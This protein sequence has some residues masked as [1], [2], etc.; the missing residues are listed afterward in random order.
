ME[1]YWKICEVSYTRWNIVIFSA[2]YDD[3]ELTI[4]TYKDT[5]RNASFTV[6]YLTAG[7]NSDDDYD[8][9][10]LLRSTDLQHVKNW[11]KTQKLPSLRDYVFSKIIDMPDITNNINELMTEFTCDDVDLSHFKRGDSD[12]E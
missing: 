2:V 11:L 1:N 10:D 3:Y 4:K 8:E 12:E 5:I 7:Y 9:E 6:S